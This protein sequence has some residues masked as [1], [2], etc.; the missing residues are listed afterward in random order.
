MAT[1]AP[2]YRGDIASNGDLVPFRV[3]ARDKVSPTAVEILLQRPNIEV[4]EDPALAQAAIIR[5]ATKFLLEGDFDAF[6]HLK[7]IA[8]AGV[9]V[10]N[11]KMLLAAQRGI[12]TVNTPGASTDA[13]ARRSLSHILS[14][15]SRV[16]QGTHALNNEQWPKNQPEVESIDLTEKTLGIIGYGRIGKRTHEFAAPH[17]GRVLF[18]DERPIEGS[19]DLDQLL[20]ESDVISLSVSGKAEVLTPKRMATIK[21]TALIVNTARGTV[22]NPEALLQHLDGGG[23]AALDVY[24]QEGAGMFDEETM[25]KISKH[26]NFIGTPHTAA[27]DPVTQKNL[28]IEAAQHVIEFA[29]EGT[30]NPGNLPGHTLPRVSLHEEAPEENG[31]GHA[32]EKP[33]IRLAL[34]H[35][36]VPGVLQGIND[37]IGKVGKDRGGRINVINQANREGRVGEPPLAMTL[38]D[39][40]LTGAEREI[41]LQVREAIRKGGVPLLKDRAMLLE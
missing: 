31:N 5:S 39:L 41:A 11:V 38:V 1:Q 8:R 22:V 21:P 6:K 35:Q 10:D 33:R 34:T 29:E 37:A 17:F 16:V 28:G 23:A 25:R 14:W 27:A 9:G 13:V 2:Q 32:I 18:N 7:Y 26:P 30:V 20:A 36:S 3:A 12:A 15:A 24:P 40:E 19:M 4:V